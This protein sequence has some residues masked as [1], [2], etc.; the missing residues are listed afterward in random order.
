MDKLN[1]GVPRRQKSKLSHKQIGR[2]DSSWARGPCSDRG[3]QQY[4][5]SHAREGNAL[6]TAPWTT[7][8]RQPFARSTDGSVLR[9]ISSSVI[10]RVNEGRNRASI[11]FLPSRRSFWTAC[12]TF[13]R[14]L[15]RF[16]LLRR[17]RIAECPAEIQPLSSP[18]FPELK[19]N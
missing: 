15:S 3:L 11:L 13:P 9:I 8:A 12:T 4:L 16:K 1:L 19:V 6:V 18:I 5:I 7:G 2:S 17:I 14:D 10:T